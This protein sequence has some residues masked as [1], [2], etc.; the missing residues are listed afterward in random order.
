MEEP[1][2]SVTTCLLFPRIERGASGTHRVAVSRGLEFCG[3]VAKATT[4][5]V[6]AISTADILDKEDNSDTRSV[7]DPAQ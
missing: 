5:E 1:V 7:S 6:S 2:E 4:Q 3:G